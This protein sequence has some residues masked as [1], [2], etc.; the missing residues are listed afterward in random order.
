MLGGIIRR[1][2][3]RKRYNCITF[4][5][6]ESYQT[7]L[8]TT[9]TDFYMWHG[10]G[11]KKWE[12][13]YRPLPSNHFRLNGDGFNQIPIDI[14]FDFILSQNKAGQ[15]PVAIQLSNMLQIPVVSIEHCL[16]MPWW[17]AHDKRYWQQTADINLFISEYSKK[18]WGYEGEVVHHG[19]DTDKFSDFGEQRNPHILSVVNDWINRGQILG[20]DIWKRVTANLP[21]AVL[22][23]TPGL[24]FPAQSV[25]H[26]VMNYNRA[27][28]FLNTSIVSPIPTSLLEAMSCGAA[29]VSTNNCMIPE[30]IENGVN[31]FLTNDEGEMRY[32]L[33]LLLKDNELARKIGREA[34]ITIQERFG[35]DKFVSRWNEIFDR[36]ANMFVKELR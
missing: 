8:A 32:Y 6:H 5:T 17:T 4:P 21:V 26:L 9:N 19:I 27:Q 1:F 7:G 31:G 25:E 20:F 14:D 16:P 36:A 33:E 23:D 2:Q 3:K 35:L 10:E 11:I 13:K 22:G 18:E 12:D 15:F 28:I 29:C 34:R 30:I 24:S